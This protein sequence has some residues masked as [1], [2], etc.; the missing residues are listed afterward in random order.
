MR[1]VT[2]AVVA[3]LLAGCANPQSTAPAVASNNAKPA[4]DNALPETGSH[5]V[6]RHNCDRHNVTV[7]GGDAVGDVMRQ[8]T[9]GTIQSH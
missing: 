3:C 8:S 6:D 7:M 2:F 5:F 4:C 1:T 9:P